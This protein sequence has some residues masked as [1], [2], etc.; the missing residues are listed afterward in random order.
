[1]CIIPVL[2]DSYFWWIV[3][4]YWGQSQYIP[5]ILPFKTKK[6][7]FPHINWFI[8]FSISLLRHVVAVLR[9]QQEKNKI[10]PHKLYSLYPNI[11]VVSSCKA[12]S[13]NCH[14]IYLFIFPCSKHNQWWSHTQYT[15]LYHIGLF[16]LYILNLTQPPFINSKVFKWIVRLR[17]YLT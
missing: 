16:L 15:V 17:K 13:L 14:Q 5:F 3:F 7:F 6:M 8:L 2:P 12:Q 4:V 9:K 11:D 1:M 10:Y